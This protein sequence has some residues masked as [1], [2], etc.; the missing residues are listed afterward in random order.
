MIEIFETIV[1]GII[2]FSQNT[3]FLLSL[4]QNV[5][6]TQ[7]IVLTLLRKIPAAF[8]LLCI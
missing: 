6:N 4:M 2:S 7:F 1:V 8:F 5:Y 3:F